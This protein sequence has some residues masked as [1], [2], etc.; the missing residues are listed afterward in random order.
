MQ[1]LVFL[2]LLIAIIA[3]IFALQNTAIATVSFLV[4]ELSSSLALILLIAVFA[5][6]LISF[7]V[8]I[9]QLVRANMKVRGLKKQV[10]DLEL[11]IK[12]QDEA[13]DILLER[14]ERYKSLAPL[15]DGV[16]FESAKSEQE[17]TG[18]TLWQG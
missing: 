6:V 17:D 8:S 16:E 13:Q 2:S 15:P 7:L 14:F 11:K 9:P 18:K 10:A 5:G 12:E 3:V 1:F 4:W